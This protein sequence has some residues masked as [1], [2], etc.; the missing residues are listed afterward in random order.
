ML[1]TADTIVTG[2]GAVTARVDRGLRDTV[3]AVGSGT[4]NR[5]A[6]HDLG[7]ATVVPGFVDTHVHGGGGGAFSSAAGAETAAAVDFHLRHGTTTLVASW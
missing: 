1:L 5:R 2:S 3:V 7:L 4:A 6:D